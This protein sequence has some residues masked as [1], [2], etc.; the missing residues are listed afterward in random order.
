MRDESVGTGCAGVMGGSSWLGFPVELELLSVEYDGDMAGIEEAAFEQI[1]TLALQ[2]EVVPGNEEEFALL[3]YQ[4]FAFA[5]GNESDSVACFLTVVFVVGRGLV[6]PVP[7][8]DDHAYP[9]GLL[10]YR[11]DYP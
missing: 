7:F 10:G 6:G 8:L 4:F 2:W 1:G 9:A 3:A 11:Y 5:V